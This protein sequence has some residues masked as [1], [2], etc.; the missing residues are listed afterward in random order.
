MRLKRSKFTLWHQ[1]RCC[2]LVVR[3]LFV[4]SGAALKLT[5]AG[6]LLNVGGFG[7]SG[8]FNEFLLVPGKPA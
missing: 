2:A 8:I 3:L 1:L 7:G 5:G 6:L 4:I